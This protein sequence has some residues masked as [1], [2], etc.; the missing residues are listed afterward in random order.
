MTGFSKVNGQADKK[1]CSEVRVACYSLSGGICPSLLQFCFVFVMMSL[2]PPAFQLCWLP[3]Q[4]FM[5]LS[6]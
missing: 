4:F 3:F 5:Q 2:E 1:G 6:C